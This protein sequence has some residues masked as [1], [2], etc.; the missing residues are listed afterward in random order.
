MF[1]APAARL[2]DGDQ[3]QAHGVGRNLGVVD[4]LNQPLPV[5]C[6][7]SD[8]KAT[9]S[10]VLAIN[11]PA[12]GVPLAEHD[13][14]QRIVP[15]PFCDEHFKECKVGE[16]LEASGGIMMQHFRDRSLRAGSWIMAMPS[17]RQSALTARNGAPSPC[18]HPGWRSDPRRLDGIFGRINS[19]KPLRKS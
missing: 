18:Y 7:T 19:N 9:A 15:L 11:V 14:L 13:P 12:K 16:L 3:L 4:V 10:C 6:R 2:F 8:Y 5:R 17:A 1:E